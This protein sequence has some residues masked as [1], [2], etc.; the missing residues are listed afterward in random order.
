MRKALLVWS[1]LAVIWGSTWI[2]IKLGLRDLPPLTFAGLRFLLAAV[3]LWGVVWIRRAKLPAQPGQW[4]ALIWTGLIAISLNYGLVFWGEHRITSGLAAVL[5]S[6]I[7]VFGLFLAHYFLPTE[8][9]T[10]RKL[11]GVALGVV[12][13]AIIFY[14]QMTIEGRAG[15]D[16]SLAL[17]CSSACVA[18]ANVLVKARLHHVDPAALAASQMLFGFVPL[19]LLGIWWEGNPLML[20]WSAVS[21]LSLLYLALV[22]SALAFLLYYWLITQIEVTKT[23]LI[24]LVTPVVALFIGSVTIGEQVTTA[25]LLGSL[26]ILGGIALIVIPRRNRIN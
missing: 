16:G 10:M 26:A 4:R 2:F 9:I 22:G 23:L 6:T 7:P 25:I 13:V 15:L 18:Y 11:G 17:L 12:G 21:I 24:S 20:R 14:D 5:Q 8:R 19:L 1:I 3:V